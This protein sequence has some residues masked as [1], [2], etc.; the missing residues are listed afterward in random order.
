M[1]H[2]KVVSIY[3]KGKLRRHARVDN[4]HLVGFSF[5]EQDFMAELPAGASPIGI[6][7]AVIDSFARHDVRIGSRRNALELE[8][9]ERECIG[10]IPVAD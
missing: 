2:C 1:H 4:G 9:K 6:W 7:I 8:M 10:V 5:F 3:P